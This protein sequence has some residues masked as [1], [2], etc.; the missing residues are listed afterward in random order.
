MKRWDLRSRMLIAWLFCMVAGSECHA[1][2]A[3]EMPING[4]ALLRQVQAGR[5]V[6]LCDLAAVVKGKHADTDKQHMDTCDH[7]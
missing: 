3:S 4:G 1:L 7:C 5:Q 6:S 2:V